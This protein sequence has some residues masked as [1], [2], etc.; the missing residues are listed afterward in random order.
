MAP[1]VS[2]PS[3]A[4]RATST[5]LATITHVPAAQHRRRSDLP[6]GSTEER[7]RLLVEGTRDYA[8][9]MLDPDGHILTWNIGAERIKGYREQEILGRHFSVF[10]SE[11]ACAA[12]H[13]AHELKLARDLGRY[14]EE[15]WRVRKDRSQFWASV[16]ITA[17]YDDTGELRGYGKVT[18]DLT[19]R[20]DSE[21]AL[22]KSEAMFRS[23]FNDAPT[24]VSVV[25]ADGR[26]QQVNAAFAQL[27]GYSV[28]A[29]LTMSFQDLTV[30][31]ERAVD[32]EALLAVVAGELSSF[33]REM[34]YRTGSG[35]EIWVSVRAVPVRDAHGV[36]TGM[37]VH[38]VDVTARHR[39]EDQMV[40]LATQD[41]LT[42]LANRAKFREQLEGH[43]RRAQRGGPVGAVL[44]IDLDHFKRVNDTL[45]HNAGDELILSLASTLRACLRA[46]DVIARLG[47]DEFAVLLPHA[48]DLE[49]DLVAGKL[50][51]AVSAEVTVLNG[52]RPRTVTA[53]VGVALIDDVT[54]SPDE[55]MVNA[56][57]AMYDAK[58]AGRN[59]HCSYSSA[60]HPMSRT[61]ARLTW[62]DRIEA[63]LADDG[64]ELWAQ[65]ILD[66][67]TNQ[68]T[69]QE[70]L[71][72]MRGADQELVSPDRFLYIAERLGLITDIDTWVTSRA[73]AL[74]ARIQPTNPRIRLEVNLSGLSVGDERL[75][76]HIASCISAAGVDPSGLVFEIT[77]TAAVER[78][79]AARDFAD[80]LRDIGC[81]FALDDFGAGFG[82]FYYLKHLPFDYVKID[83]EFISSCMSNPTDRLVIESVVS[84]ARGLGK[85]T[86][87]EFVGDEATLRYL[88][89]RQVDYAQGYHIGR[90]IPVEQAFLESVVPIQ[91]TAGQHG[92]LGE[93]ST[94][95]AHLPVHPLR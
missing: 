45:G 53:S 54:L 81:R 52:T 36:V 50:V 62:A 69:A 74:L 57:L 3:S 77:E 58:E 73:I 33:A 30:P 11:A 66:L 29:L 60:E 26:F 47:G 80:A 40:A 15:G 13:P 12:G 61:R 78:I 41:P 63:A 9:L 88:Q 10:Y 43:L 20:R 8:I 28:E 75:R 17:L 35:E 6:L 38:T 83:G 27:A 14:E 76:D 92:A 89:T 32:R 39:H 84:I 49:S 79:L 5:E 71:L 2:G 93:W 82:S 70:L 51:A 64:F 42:G 22:R 34:R 68:V 46:D 48:D 31:E 21:L 37:L 95:G 91:R 56:D 23:A 1:S 24:G 94:P 90:P 16:V 59:Q 7:L 19:E 67:H 18:R 87:A 65:P 25:G 86:I 44:M 4:K 85:E 55:V 72:R